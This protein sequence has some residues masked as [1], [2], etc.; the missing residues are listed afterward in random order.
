MYA[1]RFRFSSSGFGLNLTS[2]PFLVSLSSA[3]ERTRRRRKIRRATINHNF[4]TISSFYNFLRYTI[5]F[6]PARV[7]SSTP[8]LKRISAEKGSEEKKKSKGKDAHG[9]WWG[10]ER[11]LTSPAIYILIK[12][13]LVLCKCGEP[14]SSRRQNFIHVY[15]H[16]TFSNK[17]GDNG[18]IQTWSRRDSAGNISFS[19]ARRRISGIVWYVVVQ[20]IFTLSMFRRGRR[21]GK[22]HNRPRYVQWNMKCLLKCYNLRSF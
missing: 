7:L 20:M 16:V 19:Y 10:R 13:R 22:L 14:F 9:P 6:P 17:S 8:R 4:L 21:G 18:I 5:F 3:N 11:P 15:S 1:N 12:K 2:S